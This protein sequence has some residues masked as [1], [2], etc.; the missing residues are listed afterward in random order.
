[1]NENVAQVIIY[2]NGT[3]RHLTTT[4]RKRMC[5]QQQETCLILGFP[6]IGTLRF[7]NLHVGLGTPTVV[8]QA[9]TCLLEMLRER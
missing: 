6:S 2:L 1:M 8:L 9:I 4:F 3:A 5:L 7:S